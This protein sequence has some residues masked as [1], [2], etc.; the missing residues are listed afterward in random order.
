MQ[1][2]LTPPEVA[3]VFSVPEKTL[4]DWRSRGLGPRYA[5]VGRHVRYAAA[6]C[7]AWAASQVVE[8][9]PA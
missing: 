4:A 9:R 5:R 3:E 2:M 6:D 1:K 7:E 8:R